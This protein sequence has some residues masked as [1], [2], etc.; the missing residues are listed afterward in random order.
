M[1]AT[2]LLNSSPRASAAPASVTLTS[3]LT[4]IGG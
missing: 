1:L 4:I 3:E 2:T